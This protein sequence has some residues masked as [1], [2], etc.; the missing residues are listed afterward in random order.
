M[1]IKI[2]RENEADYQA[3]EV[4]T[5]E[6]FWNLDR[7]GCDE[8]YLVHTLRNHPDFL[9]ELAFVAVDGEQLVGSILFTKSRVERED[10]MAFDTLTFGP[11]CVRPDHQRRG[12]G[13]ELVRHAAKSAAGLGHRAFIILGSPNNYCPMGFRNTKDF[14][15]SDEQGRYPYGQLALELYADALGGVNGKFHYS[16]AYE[17]D[18]NE[19]EE[20]DKRFPEKEKRSQPS[21]VLFAMECQAFLD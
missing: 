17:F 11:L 1:N 10:G 15:I 3:V 12:I 8:H 20:Y 13:K 16:S 4:L 9:P 2:R 19:A 21:Q 5:R 6:A 7:P 14:G 18:P